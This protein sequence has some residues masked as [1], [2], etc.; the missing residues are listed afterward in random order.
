[1]TSIAC[2]QEERL[3]TP[4]SVPFRWAH[5]SQTEANERMQQAYTKLGRDVMQGAYTNVLQDKKLGNISRVQTINQWR[6]VLAGKDPISQQRS[7]NGQ[8]TLANGMDPVQKS[9]EEEKLI[10][11]LVNADAMD[12]SDLDQRTREAS[13]GLQSGEVHPD[14][15]KALFNGWDAYARQ[16]PQR[17]G[18]EASDKMAGLVG[19]MAVGAYMGRDSSTWDAKSPAARQ[20][21]IA[22]VGA[23]AK[24]IAVEQA[25][26]YGVQ[27]PEYA[28]T[29]A[30]N[31]AQET[32]QQQ[33][34]RVEAEKNHDMAGFAQR[35]LPSGQKVAPL[36]DPQNFSLGLL[37]QN[38]QTVQQAARDQDTLTKVNPPS[39]PGAARG[40]ITKAQSSQIA[41]QLSDPS[42]LNERA[43]AQGIYNLKDAYGPYAPSVMQQM[44]NDGKLDPKWQV[45]MLHANDKDLVTMTAIVSAARSGPEVDKLFKEQMETKNAPSAEQNVKDS[46]H[47]YFGDYISANAQAYPLGVARQQLDQSTRGLGE[48]YAK[49]LMI[50]N[51]DLSPDDA[52]HTAYQQMI[53]SHWHTDSVGGGWRQ[54]SSRQGSYGVPTNVDGRQLG[55]KDFANIRTNLNEFMK[56]ENLAKYPRGVQIPSQANGQPSVVADK[57]LP[58][59]SGNAHPVYSDGDKGFK[60]LYSN[61]GTDGIQSPERTLL[62]GRGDPVI[63]H[64]NDALRTPSAP[65][66]PKT[67]KWQPGVAQ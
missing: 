30:A 51:P 16:D 55:D 62:D 52:A 59:V 28:G 7:A 43:A 9:V 32:L 54:T 67:E 17:R 15:L 31:S 64:L 25:T 37:A 23:K 11:L 49:Q 63:F 6:Q 8:M 26:K 18:G 41:A 45:A 24:S 58:M 13:A 35:I 12:K 22:G 5:S 14:A 21:D 47:K 38:A 60:I 57:F 56:A 33:Y 61:Q 40:P 19:D 10:R 29:M 44:I 46:V 4:L 1:M 65:A 27:N 66:I 34:N 20:L 36:F 39:E 42:T 3:N 2:V 48:T 53:G 50:D